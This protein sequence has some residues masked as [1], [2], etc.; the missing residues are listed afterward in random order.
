M[1]IRKAVLYGQGDLRMETAAIPDEPGPNQ[2]LVET[3]ISA[4]STGT[5][6]AN[7]LGDSTYVP[8]APDY[9]RPVGYSNAGHVMAAGRDVTS[10]KP[11][12]RVFSIRAHLSHFIAD[13]TDLLV[14]IPDS[15]PSATAGLAYLTG[16]GLAALRQARY[17]TGENIVVVGLGVIGLSTV[18][19]ARAMGANV[20]GVANSEIRARAALAVGANGCLSSEDPAA[21]QSMRGYFHGLDAD[22]VVLTSNSWDSYFLSLDL[23]RRG[24]RVSILG[25][26]GRLQPMPERNP[27]HPSPFYSKQLAL[28]GAGAAPRLEC[29]PEDVRFNLRRNLEYILDLM[30]TG[31]MDLAPL[32]THTLPAR[33]MREAY[34]LARLRSKELIAAVFDWRSGE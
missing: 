7:Y 2:V 3:E 12:D 9:P 1:Q 20:L 23:A 28:F 6:L 29:G 5:D 21:V 33:R 22:I 14:Q 8:G 25:F 10:L 32:I 24:G 34:E 4:L 15:V 30:A 27:L 17:E 26:P 16:L 18:A 19:L 31:R 11:G 13:S